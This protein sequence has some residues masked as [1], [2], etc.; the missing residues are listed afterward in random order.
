MRSLESY[1]QAFAEFVLT[2]NGAPLRFG[3][4]GNDEAGMLSIYRNNV[5]AGLTGAL[6]TAYPAVK[7]LV[8]EGY[9]AQAARSFI[10]A[11]PP[12][13]PMLAYYGEAFP[14]FL[15]DEPS[16]SPYPFVPDVAR[17]EWARNRANLSETGTALTPQ[18]FARR[19]AGEDKR[20]LALGRGVTLL[21][22]AFPV[23]AIWEYAR[24][25]LKRCP[26]LGAGPVSLVVYRKGEGI[27][28]DRV[29]EPAFDL[30][31]KIE[32]GRPAG[33]SHGE[34]AEAIAEPLIAELGLLFAKGIFAEAAVGGE[35][36]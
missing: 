24:G 30:L 9:F 14:A 25:W 13:N 27:F 12:A 23:L 18:E 32:T 6:A 11:H 26:D 5:V 20:P 28:A 17:L 16:L 2:G 19:L 8:G 15:E 10:A 22:S 4:V 36:P 29:S 34:A 31:S 3:F 7:S 1:Q 33:L 35:N 21:R